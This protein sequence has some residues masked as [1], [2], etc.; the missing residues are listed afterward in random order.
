MELT[1]DTKLM[2]VLAEYPWLREELAE[3]YPK[4]KA[5]DT[6]LGRLFLKNAT[7]GELAAKAGRTPEHLLGRLEGMI[8]EHAR[9]E[10]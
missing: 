6:R 1:K 9:K 10:D 3:K 8:A 2:D 7:I 4:F 5:L